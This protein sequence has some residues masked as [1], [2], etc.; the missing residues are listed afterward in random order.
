VL[1]EIRRGLDLPIR[2]QPSQTV[3]A[4]APITRVGVLADDFPGLEPHL[5][6][7]EGE[8]VRRGQPL[9]EDRRVHGVVHTAP[10]AGRVI[11]VHRGAR[12]RLQS[13]V[14]HLSEAERA[15][16]LVADEEVAFT[17]FHDAPVD[18]LSRPDIVALLVESGLWTALR[19]RPFSHVPAIDSEPEAL[20]VTA[21]DTHPLAPDPAVVIAACADAFRDGLRVLTKLTSGATHVCVADGSAVENEIPAA[22]EVQRFAGPH[23]SGLAGTHVHFVHPVDREHTVWTI[24][25]QDVIAVGRLFASGRLD[26]ERVISIAGPPIAE[27][28]LVRTRLGACLEELVA[29]EGL[30]DRDVRLV[31]GSVLSG[32]RSPSGPF[33]YLGRYDVQL[34]VVREGTER[35]FLGWLRPGR[36]KYS[37]VPAFLSALSRRKRFAFTTNMQGSP[38]A[39]IPIGVYER[40]MP[41][42]IL[43]TFLLRSLL[44]GDT[45]TAEALGCLELDEEDLALCTFVCPSKID[46]GPALR[47]NLEQIREELS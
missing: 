15:G 33:G 18:G 47:Q 1:H 31:S 34:S 13:V 32:K 14:I 3:G 23:P 5:R 16:A 30:D 21:T 38:R 24:G 9:F 44:V 6:V 10:A 2:G 19:T 27:P 26:P 4:A 35:E 29:D 40:V 41:L 39:I 17:S 43:P 7:G 11:G 45:E 42:D 37:V 12:R 36:D 8:T 25:Y 22:C 46:Y 28:R 20:F